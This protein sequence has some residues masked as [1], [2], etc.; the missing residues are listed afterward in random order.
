MTSYI[1]TYTPPPI[2]KKEVLRYAGVAKT[3]DGTA[4]LPLVDEC[5]A[6]A[7]SVFTYKVC[8]RE[9]PVYRTSD[10]LDLG[11]AKTVS[12]ALQKNLDGCDAVILF[13][14][15][16]GV[17][18]DR[19]ISKYTRLSPAKAL[20]FQALGAE[21]VEALVDTFYAE[22]KSEKTTVHKSLRPRFSAGF[23]D[24][25]LTFQKEIFS[26]LGA[27]KAVG[28][29]LSDSM[30]MSPTKSVTALIGVANM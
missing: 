17:G 26:A 13:A 20:I 12:R 30:L 25:P 5:I 3:A 8:Y 14:A 10:A 22:Q 24:L 19:L 21:R 7:E 2:D 11:F 23:G 28:I 16:V 9:F 6:E 1:K 27:E 18:I 4:L 15:T 29:Y